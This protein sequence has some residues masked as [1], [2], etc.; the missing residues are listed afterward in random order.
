MEV[1]IIAMND[2]VSRYEGVVIV[3]V[4]AGITTDCH[5]A[6]SLEASDE[7]NDCVIDLS[8]LPPGT[9]RLKLEVRP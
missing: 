1:S 9:T 5:P 2:K 7:G 8:Q 4:S 3:D 6:A